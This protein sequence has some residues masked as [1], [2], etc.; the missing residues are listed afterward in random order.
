MPLPS[1]KIA[2]QRDC[3]PVHSQKCIDAFFDSFFPVQRRHLDTGDL[4]LVLGDFTCTESPQL[5]VHSPLHPGNFGH[6]H[7]PSG[8]FYLCLALHQSEPLCPSLGLVLNLPGSHVQ[9]VS[10]QVLKNS[11]NAFITTQTQIIKTSAGGRG[12][13][14]KCEDKTSLLGTGSSWIT[15]ENLLILKPI[16]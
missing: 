5:S 6:L 9:C 15:Q 1:V 4:T 11:P 7:C 13:S 3:T 12:R 14:G 16:D 2:S 10:L 8:N